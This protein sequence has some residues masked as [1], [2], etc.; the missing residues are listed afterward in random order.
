MSED[1]I[2][3]KYI[4]CGTCVERCQMKAVTLQND[5]AVVDRKKCIGCGLCVTGC[6]LKVAQL[7][8]RPET[9]G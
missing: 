3:S 6:G 4:G 2:S 5:I 9:K 8:L 1:V 7:Q